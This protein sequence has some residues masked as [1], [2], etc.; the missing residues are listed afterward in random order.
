MCRG[1]RFY[2]QRTKPRLK[3]SLHLHP[4]FQWLPG[5]GENLRSTDQCFSATIEGETDLCAGPKWGHVEA[6]MAMANLLHNSVI[7]LSPDRF[8]YH[9][10]G[11]LARAGGTYL[12]SC[13]RFAI[14]ANYGSRLCEV[15]SPRRRNKTT[16]I[17]ES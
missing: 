14:S 2:G 8:Q 16:P 1:S 5:C 9:Y 15:C 12:K 10:F 11:G 17:N 3:R 7:G 13:L 6:I 4:R